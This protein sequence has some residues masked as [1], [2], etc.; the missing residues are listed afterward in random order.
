MNRNLEYVQF[1]GIGTMSR[2]IQHWTRDLDSHSAVLDR[3]V[4]GF[5]RLIEQWPHGGGLKSW[6]DFNDFS[7]HTEGTTFQIWSLEVS[8]KYYDI[9]MDKYRES[10][11][12][13][14]PYDWAGIRDFGFHGDGDPDKT[15]CSEEMIMHLADIMGWDRIKPVT[16][17][18][19]QFR[20]IL[21]AAGAKP[22]IKGEV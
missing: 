22:T 1:Q 11:R 9:V 14:K 12:A 5:K 16:I 4:D 3:E 7:G 18:P 2:I 20:N 15:F 17:S 21:Q 8:S 19:G 13:K 6:M 10:A